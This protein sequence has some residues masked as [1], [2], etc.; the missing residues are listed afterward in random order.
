MFKQQD[1]VGIGFHAIEQVVRLK[2]FSE[3]A[4]TLLCPPWNYEL[5]EGGFVGNILFALTRLGLKTGYLGMVGGDQFGIRLMKSR[6]TEAI[7]FSH[8]EIIPS[9]ESAKSWLILNERGEQRRILFPNILSQVDEDYIMQ[10][11]SYIKSCRLL[12]IDVS[13]VPLSACVLAAELAKSELIPVLVCLNIPEGELFGTLK[14]GT[15]AELEELISFSDLFLAS[16][17]DLK[18]LTPTKEPF[19]QAEYLQKKYLIPN[20]V[21]LEGQEGCVIAVEGEI[22][23][24][25]AFKVEMLDPLGYRDAFMAGM[26]FGFFHNWSL[27]MTARFANACAAL[28]SLSTGVHSGMKS[29]EDIMRFLS[30]HS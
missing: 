9:S 30:K 19:K 4:H 21:L 2:D 28:N 11:A 13:V 16:F 25:P 14:S 7:D 24:S 20:T 23:R 1:V 26:S 15:S 6:I 29:E 5:I 12:L 17:E 27:P 22:S 18:H 3:T 8:C 10:H